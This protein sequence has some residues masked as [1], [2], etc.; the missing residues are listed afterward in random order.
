MISFA[1]CFKPRWVRASV[2]IHWYAKTI[3]HPDGDNAVAT[4]KS[5]F[6]GLTDYGI[7]ADDK[8]VTYPPAIF[9]KDRE[10]PR[11][12]LHITG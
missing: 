2:Q 11:I 12:E 1:A 7:F 3:A 8:H 10:N 6:D 4:L 5:A 9:H